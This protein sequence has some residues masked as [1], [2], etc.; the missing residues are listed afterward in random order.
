MHHRSTIGA[1]AEHQSEHLTSACTIGAQSV[2]THQ[3][4]WIGA[5]SDFCSHRSTIRAPSV[6]HRSTIGA[7]SEH[8][9]STIEAPSEHLTFTCYRPMVGAH[10]VRWV[11]PP[12]FATRLIE[13]EPSSWLGNWIFLNSS[14]DR[15]YFYPKC[16]QICTRTYIVIYVNPL[17]QTIPDLRKARFE[18]KCRQ[19]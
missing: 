4:R 17:T 6:H 16:Y 7:P 13:A 15:N 18:L 8:H 2:G 1:P 5:P 19:K 3:V 10:Q 9:R 14:P 12:T 11:G